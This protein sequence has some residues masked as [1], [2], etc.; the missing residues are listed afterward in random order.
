[1]M[2]VR[3]V[4]GEWVA[5]VGVDRWLLVG[6]EP[7]TAVVDRWW[8][9]VRDGATLDELHTTI[10][11]DGIDRYVAI[12]HE[13]MGLRVITRGGP[14]VDVASVGGPAVVV[15]V[16]DPMTCVDRVIPGPVE[17]VAVYG[18]ASE[19]PVRL[20]V[21]GGVVLAGGLWIGEG[22]EPASPARAAPVEDAPSPAAMAPV[23]AA[24]VAQPAPEASEPVPAAAA[25]E[26]TSGYHHLFGATVLPAAPVVEDEPVVSSVEPT[27][28]PPASVPQPVLPSPPPVRQTP[29]E[30][31]SDGLIGPIPWLPPRGLSS[32]RGGIADEPPEPPTR[33]GA[34][35]ST[36]TASTAATPTAASS[37]ATR[38]NVRPRADAG[39]AVVSAVACQQGHPNPPTAVVCRQCDGAVPRGQ[40]PYDVPRPAL[41]MLRPLAGGEP[42]VLERTVVLGRNPQVPPSQSRNVIR[43]LS[44]RG[45]V[46]GTHLEVALDG[47]SVTVEDLGSTNGTTVTAAGVTRE[48]TPRE[49][50]VIESGSVVTLGG[51]VA[52]CFE[53]GPR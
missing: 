18:C 33:L 14:V 32:A 43:L 20:P 42:V 22:D 50:V 34:T 37:V 47:W 26:P 24:E 4:P 23:V 27:P 7:D 41:G 49:P 11:R 38:T 30:Q 45:E 19:S 40:H 31:V 10:R 48:L 13:S 9:L 29:V 44:P 15:R 36:T 6:A 12:A 16:D 39:A 51:E 3:Y 21:D 35:P 25:P 5:V 52:L 1:M 17:R 53:T 8:A 28:P 2:E 46:S